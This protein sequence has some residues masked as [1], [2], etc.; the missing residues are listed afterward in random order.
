[1][2]YWQ[3]QGS[4]QSR[5][6]N[7]SRNLGNSRAAKAGTSTEAG[8]SAT[9]GWNRHSLKMAKNY[10]N[11]VC[12]QGLWFWIRNNG[13][14][15]IYCIQCWPA[16]IGSGFPIDLNESGSF[17]D[18]DPDPKLFKGTRNFCGTTRYSAIL[19]SEKFRGIT[20]NSAEGN[21]F[22][23]KF[24]LP[25]NYKKPFPYT[26][27]CTVIFYLLTSCSFCIK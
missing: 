1:M 16:C 24:R 7:S 10:G 22:L 3:Q 18:Q 8:T 11:T 5:D 15:V 23:K 6:A 4:Q 9:A 19:N 26:L 27:V 25:R 12:W 21:H 14:V 13:S 2:S 17:L 20:W